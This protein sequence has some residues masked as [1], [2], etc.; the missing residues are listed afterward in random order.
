MATLENIFVSICIIALCVLVVVAV[1]A[2]IAMLVFSIIGIAKE[3]A[4]GK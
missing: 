3:I 4:D 2:S 1:L